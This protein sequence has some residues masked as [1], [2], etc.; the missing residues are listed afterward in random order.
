MDQSKEKR[1]LKRAVHFDFH[2]MPGIYDFC[3]DFDAAAFAE[4]LKQSHVTMINFFAQCN[5]GF[6][7]Y[8]TKVGIP[9]P[10]MKGDL[11]GD[12]LRECHKRGIQVVAYMNAGLNHEMARRHAD[13]CQITRDGEVIHGDR[14]NGNFFRT[15]CYNTGYGEHALNV[16]REICENYDVDGIFCDCMNVRPCWCSRCTEDML[17]RGI[18][19]DDVA[20]VKDFSEEVMLNFSRRIRQVV[21]K[22]KLLILNT[23][24]D[25]EKVKDLQY[26]MEVECLPSSGL[27]GYDTFWAHASYARNLQKDV[28]YMTGRFQSCWGDFG[29][30]KAKASLEHDIYDA[31]CAGVQFSV[32]DHLHPARNL[33]MGLYDMVE[34]I[35]GRM[36]KYEKY[37][38]NA[39]FQSDI[40]VIHNLE[41]RLV[42]HE[43]GIVR[44]LLELKQSFDIV[45]EN[46]DLD[47][48]RLLILPDAIRM[49]E[50]LQE[51]LQRYLD[52]GGKVLFSGESGLDAEKTDFAFSALREMLS[53]D[54]KDASNSSYYVTREKI[55]EAQME[56]SMYQEGILMKAKDDRDVVADYVKPY[57]NHH[58]DGLHSY[59]YTPQ[60]KKTG[61]AAVVKRGNLAYICFN[62]FGAYYNYASVFHK[63]LVEYLLK[64]LLP[65]PL[66]RAED[67]PSTSRV[68]LTGTDD[69]KLLHVKTTFPEPRGKKNIV[70][71]H[72]TLPAGREILVRGEYK[73]VCLLPQETPVEACVEGGYT[74]ITL[75][76]I[77]GYDM[78]LIR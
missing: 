61:H 3:R 16:I 2:T 22:D 8:P 10:T 65:R 31:M 69:Y 21:P 12:V 42:D 49:T 18:D 48:F 27:W 59:Y 54:G 53:L 36:M 41:G 7:Y 14:V 57:F 19:L 75:P 51:K 45:N 56:Y 4:K 5:I 46:M 20:A 77:T 6:S 40:G 52:R 15:N 76:E 68:T 60:E 33:E 66:I 35:Y 28:L 1:Y 62:V 72:V 70:E 73:E 30:L 13:W 63:K 47:R 25:K 58:W 29:G 38:D 34:E 74:K 67:M 37:T 44:M 9:Y 11:F 55:C 17:A 78:F 32:G 24:M 39:V 43:R 23:S 50:K 71:E 26:H 64:D